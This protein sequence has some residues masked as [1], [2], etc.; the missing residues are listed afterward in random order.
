[1]WEIRIEDGE[2]R[3]SCVSRITLAVVPEQPG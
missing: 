3:L 1:V 2:G